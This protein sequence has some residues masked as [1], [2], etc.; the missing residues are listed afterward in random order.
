MRILRTLLIIQSGYVLITAV[1]PLVSIDSFMLVTGYKTDTWL[2]KTVGALLIPIA[3]CL[4]SFLLIETDKRPAI[5]LGGLTALAFAI[6]DFYYALK[7][8]I[9]KIY[10][11][12][13]VLELLFL[14]GWI[15]VALKEKAWKNFS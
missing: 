12:D 6:I 15:Y 8:Q 10:M 13:G 11:L 14:V 9:P 2:V 4:G 5:I 1:W 7:H 3:C